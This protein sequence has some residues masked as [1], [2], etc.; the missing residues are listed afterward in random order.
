MDTKERAR[1]LN[2]AQIDFNRKRD[3]WAYDK[4]KTEIYPIFIEC[5]II[6]TEKSCDKKWREKIQKRIEYLDAD[7]CGFSILSRE[8]RIEEVKALLVRK[9]GTEEKEE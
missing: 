9:P 5:V 6:A 8:I 1:I 7:D 2:N 4:T 3:K